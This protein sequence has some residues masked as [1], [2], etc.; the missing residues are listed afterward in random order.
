MSL[1]F[2]SKAIAISQMLGSS[3][4]LW[5]VVCL[6]LGVALS[7]HRV[8]CVGILSALSYSDYVFRVLLLQGW[9]WWVLHCKTQLSFVLVR[10]MLTESSPE[11][12]RGQYGGLILRTLSYLAVNSQDEL[13]LLS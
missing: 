12:S 3:P 11:L 9:G 6:S 5:Q 4:I 7:F 1:W 8:I 2:Q 10:L 13:T